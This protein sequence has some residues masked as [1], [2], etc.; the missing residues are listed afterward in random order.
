MLPMLFLHLYPTT[1]KLPLQIPILFASSQL[2]LYLTLKF[3][4]YGSDK[5]TNPELDV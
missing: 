4:Q 3:K 1:K 2:W 5:W